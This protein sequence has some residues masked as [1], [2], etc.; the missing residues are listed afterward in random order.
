MS[1]L[2]TQSTTQT[3][4]DLEL[5]IADNIKSRA[6]RETKKSVIAVRAL[7]TVSTKQEQ[8]LYTSAFEAG[9]R[10]A[11]KFLATQEHNV[12]KCEVSYKALDE[13]GYFSVVVSLEGSVVSNDWEFYQPMR[14]YLRH[15]LTW[16]L[17]DYE[18]KTPPLICD[19]IFGSFGFSLG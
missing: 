7:H 14:D 10:M 5:V 18:L 15:C 19:I 17:L 4:Q 2:V 8:L 13:T 3:L 6:I 11:S 16:T 1:T 12:E 9:T